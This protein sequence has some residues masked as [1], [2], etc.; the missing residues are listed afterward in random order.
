MQKHILP[1][2]ICAGLVLLV[3]SVCVLYPT[4]SQAANPDWLGTVPNEYVAATTIGGNTANIGTANISTLAINSSSALAGTTQISGILQIPTVD[5]T[6]T[7]PTKTVVVSGTANPIAINL[8]TSVS[9]TGCLLSGG[10]K[11]QIVLIR[12]TSDSA[13]TRWDDNATTMALGGNLTLGV[14]DWL[15][16][17]C[18]SSSPQKWERL[19]NVDN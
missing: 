7:S 9:Q 1:L 8:T 6:I 11:G 2:A 19:F 3:V 12:G 16:L 10:I 18:S 14:T 15:A 13:T 5:V 17:R 4:D